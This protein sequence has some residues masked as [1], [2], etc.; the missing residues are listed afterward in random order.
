MVISVFQLPVGR[1]CIE[2]YRSLCRQCVFSHEEL[3]CKMAADPDNLD[4]IIA[5]STHKDLLAIVEDERKQR[6][7]L[8]EMV[9]PS[10]DC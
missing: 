3:V 2:H 6:K 9:R 8:L 1:A 5:A 7:V 4:L 10:E